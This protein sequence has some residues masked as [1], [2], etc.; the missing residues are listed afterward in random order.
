MTTIISITNLAAGDISNLSSAV[1]PAVG[2]PELNKAD[3]STPNNVVLNN[4]QSVEVLQF[5]RNEGI[6][7]G[8]S[9][10]FTTSFELDGIQI[11]LK[12]KVTGTTAGSTMSQCMAAGSQATTHMIDTGKPT[13]ITFTGNSGAVYSLSWDLTLHVGGVY[14]NIHYTVTQTQP[15]YIAIEPVMQQIETVVY[16]ML[17]NRS[18]DNVLG[19]LYDGDKPAIVYPPNSSDD[20]NGLKGNEQND[21]KGTSY[22]P[23]KDT[24]SFANS[25][26]N[27]SR[28]PV[29]DPHEPMPHVL[30]QFYA[31]ANG[32]LPAA[33]YIWATEPL[34]T[35]FVWDYR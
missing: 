18:L 29:V 12:E 10:T 4:S 20:F 21:Y 23:A 16:L 15:A 34:M 31:D 26:A 25:S 24:T 17:E 14:D 13:A 35:G 32:N 2:S 8:K 9:W 19:W 22:A 11:L 27:S 28:I 7:N 3:W 5:N 30:Q 1:A 6:K 33:E